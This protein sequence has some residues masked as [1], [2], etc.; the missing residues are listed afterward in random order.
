MILIFF[1]LVLSRMPGVR[2]THRQR[3]CLTAVVGAPNLF[4][5]PP[6]RK[7][8]KVITLN[9]IINLLL[10]Y[11]PC[12][13]YTLYGLREQLTNDSEDA[14]GGKNVFVIF[15]AHPRNF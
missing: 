8:T 15:A 11:L 5:P 9:I 7:I 3:H 1:K 14:W 10:L 6:M 4:T 2:L 13:R 12:Q